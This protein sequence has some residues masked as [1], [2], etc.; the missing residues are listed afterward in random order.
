M[1]RACLLFCGL[2]T[3]ASPA[4]AGEICVTCLAPDAH[5]RCAFEGDKSAAIDPSLP[6]VCLS[7][8]SEAGK[9]Q[10]CMIERHST[11]PCNGLMKFV[12]RPGGSAASGPPS[13]QDAPRDSGAADPATAAKSAAGAPP[14][15]PESV[16]DTS[17]EADPAAAGSSVAKHDA[18]TPAAQ[19]GPEAAPKTLKEL[20]DKGAQ[21]S[22]EALDKAG[23]SAKETAKDAADTTGSALSKAG[24]SVGNAAK[25]TWKCLTSLFGDC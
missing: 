14:A 15:T 23:E 16:P 24:Q 20:V 11:Q 10:S 2:C 22:K 3:A 18:A 12:A 8:L 13:K 21:T 25:K 9:H 6:L 7:A 19:P 4:L 1:L 17:P 5:Y